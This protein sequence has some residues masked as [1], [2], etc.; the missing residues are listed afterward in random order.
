MASRPALSTVP[1]M[2]M[3]V[4]LVQQQAEMDVSPLIPLMMKS[5][6]ALVK[7]LLVLPS[8]HT[9]LASRRSIH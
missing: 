7:M 1:P 4:P 9:A 6:V 5:L 2:M 8:L 3:I